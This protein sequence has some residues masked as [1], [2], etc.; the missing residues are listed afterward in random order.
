MLDRRFDRPDYTIYVGI[1]RWA[2]R[3]VSLWQQGVRHGLPAS[4]PAYVETQLAAG[5]PGHVLDVAGPIGQW[6]GAFGPQSMLVIS[7]EQALEA[8]GDVATHV[9]K[10]LFGLAIPAQRYVANVSMIQKTELLRAISSRHGAQP[11][12]ERRAIIRSLLRFWERGKP[13]VLEAARLIEHRLRSLPL[14]DDHPLFRQL[15]ARSGYTFAARPARSWAYA[16]DEAFQDR[17]VAALLAEIDRRAV[18]RAARVA[19]E[20]AREGAV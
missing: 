4:L 9:F 17:P 6:S 20:R 15:E 12:G 19:G 5:P 14:A 10:R 11:P 13:M 7:L 2:D 3:L 1:R 18:A 8:D 16:P